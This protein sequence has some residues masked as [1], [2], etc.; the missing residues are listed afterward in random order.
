MGM[1]LY[2]GIFDGWVEVRECERGVGHENAWDECL[3]MPMP[4]Y[5]WVGECEEKR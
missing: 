5:G 3:Y 4:G 1:V 2:V